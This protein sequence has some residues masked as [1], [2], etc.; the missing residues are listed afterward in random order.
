M[1]ME[2][3]QEIIDRAEARGWFSQPMAA[4]IPFME[5]EMRSACTQALLQALDRPHRLAFVLGAVIEVSSMEGAYILDIS[6]AAFRKRLSRARAR[7]KD[8]LTA[9]CGF[10][11]ESNRCKCTSIYS[12]HVKQGWID[13]QRPIFVSTDDESEDPMILRQYLQE[14]DELSR[15]SAFFKSVLDNTGSTDFAAIVKSMVENND[16]RILSDPQLV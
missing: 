14:L 16:Y 6:P 13:P 15:I 4:P 9:N 11:G 12:G 2:K 1:N 7:I 10:F 3:A 5:A 8:F